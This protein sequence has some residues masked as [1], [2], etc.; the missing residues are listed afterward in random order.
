L[1]GRGNRNSKE[2]KAQGPPA[3]ADAPKGKPRRR[4]S[5]AEQR[6]FDRQR[7]A[8][9][10]V[11]QKWAPTRKLS[12][13]E[14][15]SAREMFFQFDADN[16]GS[17]D[18]EEIGRMM[19]SLGQNPNPSEIQELINSV[20]EGDKDGQLQMREFLKLFSM[21]IDTKGAA[22]GSDVNNCFSFL[23]GDPR[24]EGSRVSGDT[25]TK[26]LYDDFG[27]D[28]GLNDLEISG[29]ELSR[30]DLER[31]ILPPIHQKRSALLK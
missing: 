16:S 2:A 27:L 9:W 11:S 12:T 28:I 13:P 3:A 19:R 30:K 5:V 26:S 17:I 15:R 23:G 20:D 14:L 22:T 6:H 31:I 7:L 1:G 8:Q 29:G 24:D 21:A 25:L 18:A 10:Q 4:M